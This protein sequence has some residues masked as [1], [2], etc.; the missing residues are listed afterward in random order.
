MANL[1]TGWAACVSEASERSGQYTQQPGQDRLGLDASESPSRPVH[2]LFLFITVCIL[3]PLPGIPPGKGHR[4]F[5]DLWG[6]SPSNWLPRAPFLL[7]TSST[8]TSQASLPTWTVSTLASS[9][10][11]QLLCPFGAHI[12]AGE[13]LAKYV[14]VRLG[15]CPS[16][17]DGFLLVFRRCSGTAKDLCSPDPEDSQG[18]AVGA[19]SLGGGSRDPW[20]PQA[21]QTLGALQ[22]GDTD[23][24]GSAGG[25]WG[26]EEVSPGPRPADG[27]TGL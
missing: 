26:E 4:E 24:M 19:G 18:G 12:A 8:C 6:G 2:V 10:P 5:K 25:K 27:H 21:S 15:K 11:I 14:S 16:C 1:P 17:R 7:P 13:Q 3:H 22:H 23:P 9:S 20:G